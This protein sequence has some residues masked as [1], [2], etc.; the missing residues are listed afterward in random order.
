MTIQEILLQH[1]PEKKNILPAIKAI[2][3]NLSWVSEEAIGKIARYFGESEAYIFSVASFYD[4]INFNKPALLTLE[5]CDGANC[6][7]KDSDNIIKNVETFFKIKVDSFNNQFVLKRM[8]CVG[9][10]LEGPVVK[11]NGTIYT[12]M[13]TDKVIELIQNYLGY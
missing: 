8:S 13:T 11:I 12:K 1:E 6:Q 9:R 7:I 5:I 2:N 10:C 3:Q 4:E